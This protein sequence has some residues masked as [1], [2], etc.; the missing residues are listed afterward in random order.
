KRQAIVSYNKSKSW[1]KIQS[2]VRAKNPNEEFTQ[3]QISQE[4]RQLI[5]CLD[6]PRHITIL[7]YFLQGYSHKEIVDKM[8]TVPSVGASKVL[9]HRAKIALRELLENDNPDP[10]RGGGILPVDK[11]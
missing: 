6:D 11:K 3:N 2:L 7:T 4:V 1:R 8:P 5:N 10:D 9:L